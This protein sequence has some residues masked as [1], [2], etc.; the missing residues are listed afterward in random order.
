[1]RDAKAAVLGSKST[2]CA[3]SAELLKRLYSELYPEYS[4]EILNDQIYIPTMYRKYSYIV[5]N[6]HRLHSV[7]H[8]GSNNPYV[9]ATPLFKFTTSTSTI[10]AISCT[11][12]VARP[13]Q[14]QYFLTHSISLSGSEKSHILAHCLWPMEHPMKSSIGKPVE[15]WCK[16]LYEPAVANTI[17]PVSTFSSHVIISTD[18]ISNDHVLITIPL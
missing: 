13:A 4:A 15:I 3:L 9:L 6:G 11:E 14:L 2:L 8:K 12:S 17:V 16:E 5:W 7:N 1:M 18:I 10:N